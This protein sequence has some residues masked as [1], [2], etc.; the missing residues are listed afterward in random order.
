M[1]AVHGYMRYGNLH[2][3]YNHYIRFLQST[4]VGMFPVSHVTTNHCTH[5]VIKRWGHVPPCPME[6]VRCSLSNI[7]GQLIFFETLVTVTIPDCVVYTIAKSSNVFSKLKCDS[8]VHFHEIRVLHVVTVERSV[9]LSRG[10]GRSS[11]SW[12]LRCS[13][14]RRRRLNDTDAWRSARSS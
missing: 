9:E 14:C 8:V 12:R 7:A 2:E 10:V 3:F 1:G 11:R 4:R 13:T 6:L 5:L